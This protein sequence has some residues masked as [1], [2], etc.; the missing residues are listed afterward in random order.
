M[1][2]EMEIKKGMK[3]ISFM[4]SELTVMGIVDKFVM[5][6]YKRCIPFVKSM[7]EMPEFLK[8]IEAK[9]IK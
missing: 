9:Q 2:V 1:A 7:K 3:W 4:G 5:L 8:F 6:R